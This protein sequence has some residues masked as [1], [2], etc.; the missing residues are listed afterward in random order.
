MSA[1]AEVSSQKI[2][3]TIRQRRPA[4][5]ERIA[6]V[7]DPYRTIPMLEI[8]PNLPVAVDLPDASA[9]EILDETTLRVDQALEMAMKILEVLP[10]G[11]WE[12]ESD[13]GEVL[14]FRLL[15]DDWKLD[16]VVLLR[17]CLFRLALDPAA[18]A[19]IEYL[20]RDLAWSLTQRYSFV[21]PN[22]LRHRID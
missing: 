9:I 2:R 4:W 6:D 21:Y 11:S 19:K 7:R 18:A 1:A 13:S 5:R 15:R 12:P 20:Q 16:S 10:A 8:V 14:R 17:K 3:T 22:A